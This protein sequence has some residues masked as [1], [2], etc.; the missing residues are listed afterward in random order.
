MNQEKIGKFIQEIRKEK[1]LTQEELALKL[2]VTSKSVSR[3]ENGNTMPDYSL[4]NLLCN[5]LNITINELLSGERIKENNYENKT[6]ENISNILKEYYKMKKQKQTIKNILIVIFILFVVLIIRILFVLGIVSLTFLNPTDNISGIE[7]YNKNYYI[8][9]YGGDL[10][11]N[12]FIFP[13][14]T[15]NMIDTSFT[16]SFQTNLFDSDGYIVLTS[17]YD[18]DNFENEIERLSKLNITILENCYPNAKTYT[19]YVKYDKES[20]NYPAYITIDGFGHT[21]EYALINENDLEIIYV[22]L[23]YPNIGNLNNKYLKKNKN[24]YSKNTLD[25]YSMYNHSFDNGKSYMEFNNC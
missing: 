24:E 12:L 23:S 22:Y 4:L 9:K 17:K 16:S 3:W 14:N 20:Y 18:K 19:N 25:L 15:S 7:N 21:Y 10:D 13:D 1:G 5:E 11:S 6:N 2:G 8:E